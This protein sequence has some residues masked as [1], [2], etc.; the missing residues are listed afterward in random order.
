MTVSDLVLTFRRGCYNIIDCGIRT[1][2]TFWAVNNLLGFTRDKKAN[3]ILFLV[4]T[5]SLK[6]SIITDY[7][8]QCINADDL[9]LYSGSWGDNPDKIGVMCYQ[10]FGARIMKEGIDFL[11]EIDC[12]CWDEC[13]S[14]FDFAATAFAKARKTDFARKDTTNE[15]ILAVIQKYSTK[16]EYMPLILLGEWENIVNCGRIMCIGLSATPERAR[17]YYMSLIHSS[18]E[19]KLQAVYR[20]G[21]DIYFHRLTELVKQLSPVPD[22]GY[23]IYS[24]YI[25]SNQKLVTLAQSLGFSAIEIHSLNNEDYPMT[26]EQIEVCNIITT[27]G[28][29]PLKYDFVIVNKAFERGITLK[30]SRFDVVIIDSIDKIACEQV[31]RNVFPYRRYLK[32]I[33]PAIPE[34]Y[35]NKWLTLPECRELASYMNIVD[36]NRKIMSWNALKDFLPHIG[37]EC[38]AQRKKIKGKAQQFYYI[39]GEWHNYYPDD[40]DFLALVDAR[41]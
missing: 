16:K 34:N 10:S 17:N 19:G 33:S 35:L 25:E 38:K 31:P 23:W 4:D 1:G 18:N 3:R 30:D 15:E 40:K 2:T 9:W 22:K 27:T 37:Y 14:I 24:P 36:K 32:A 11:K 21:E 7:K 20:I 6:D 8:E 29:V 39:T 12:I 41:Q 13:D 26:R 5:N 28:M